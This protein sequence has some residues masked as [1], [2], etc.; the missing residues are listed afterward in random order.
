[1]PTKQSIINDALSNTANNLASEE[2]FDAAED[3]GSFEWERARRAYER[4]LP[5][6]LERHAWPFAKKVEALTIVDEDS[7][8]SNRYAQAYNWPP[9]ALWL[10]TIESPGGGAI[11]YEIIGRMIGMDYDG[12]GTDA[13]IAT[14]IAMP[15]TNAIS[16]LFWEV[17]RL[18]V[19][20]G[21]LRSI[22]EDYAEAT[23]RDNAAELLLAGQARARV[24]QQSPP[25]RG[26]YSTMRER[27]RTGGGPSSL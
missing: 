23:R 22:N 21:C 11:P 15:P 10:Q 7:N 4:E 6:L 8:P 12:T 9:S 16:N 18:K 13:P 1:L 25:R 3:E 17:L 26:F 5:L 27:R 24:D 19:E 20:V 2:D 14:F